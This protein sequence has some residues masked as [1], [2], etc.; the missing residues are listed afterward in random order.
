MD[1]GEEDSESTALLPKSILMGKKFKPG[2]EVVLKI[3]HIY[4]DE[5][6]VAYAKSSDQEE[7][8]DDGS[9]M[10]RSSSPMKSSMGA[11]DQMAM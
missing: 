4:D 7:E 6:E 2:E 9:E 3:V 10:D 5:V 11:M 1:K 8:K